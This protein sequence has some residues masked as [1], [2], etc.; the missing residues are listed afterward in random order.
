MDP[1]RDHRI[2]SE[3][4]L[5]PSVDRFINNGRAN[6]EPRSCTGS[7]NQFVIC[8]QD[9]RRSISV[10]TPRT[11]Q[12]ALD[13]LGRIHPIHPINGK[14]KRIY[15][16]D[17]CPSSRILSCTPRHQRISKVLSGFTLGRQHPCTVSQP[18]L[19][20]QVLDASGCYMLHYAHLLS[21][22]ST[23]TGILIRMD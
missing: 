1:W 8:N 23:K 17:I 15:W 2:F 10:G 22:M 5:Q 19:S 12:T 11:L 4:N 3:I 13:Q 14:Y 20:S 7:W 21:V 6:V 9:P 18:L 16:H